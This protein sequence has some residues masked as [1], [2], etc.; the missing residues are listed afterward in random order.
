VTSL[1][2]GT[3]KVEVKLKWDPSPLG[4]PASD[5]DIIAATYYANDPHGKPA[6][7]VRFDSR[8]PDGT[9]TLDRDSVNGKGLGWDEA[10]TVELDRLSASYARVVVGVAIQQLGGRMTFGDIANPASLVQTGYTELAKSNFSDVA[11]YTAAVIAEFARHGS[12]EWEFNPSVRGFD[13][14]PES[15]AQLMGGRPS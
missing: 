7:L 10:M 1:N 6:Y 11:G 15:F 12:E 5:L 3:R 13:A 2:K 9:I 8:S 4:A 14:D